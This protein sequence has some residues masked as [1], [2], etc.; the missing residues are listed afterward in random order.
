MI[1][2][3][4]LPKKYIGESKEKLLPL[5]ERGLNATAAKLDYSAIDVIKE[6][7]VANAQCWLA[8]ETFDI[9]EADDKEFKLLGIAI[10]RVLRFPRRDVLQ[11]FLVSGER[12]DDWMKIGLDTIEAYARDKNCASMRG[13]G[14]FGWKRKLKGHD[15]ETSL[16]WSKEL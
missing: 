13:V 3:F 10:T 9:A 6:L 2:F 16:V 15:L 4:V 8:T 1:D 11:I 5:I 7:L 14:R 12:I